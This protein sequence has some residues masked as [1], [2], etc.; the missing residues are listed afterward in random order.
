L[1]TPHHHASIR[2]RLRR[3]FNFLPHPHKTHQQI[4]DPTTAKKTG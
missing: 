1:G 2:V 4:D 3:K